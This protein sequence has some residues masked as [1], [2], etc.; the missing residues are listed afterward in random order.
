MDKETIKKEPSESQPEKVKEFTSFDDFSMNAKVEGLRPRREYVGGDP[1]EIIIV[2][3]KKYKK[4]V[5][6]HTEMDILGQ[7]VPKR[8]AT[9]QEYYSH[10][11]PGWDYRSDYMEKM[12]VDSLDPRDLSD[13]ILYELEEIES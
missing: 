6:Y 3:G 2:E 1:D 5:K 9:E 12:G 4:V 13:L 7:S 11:C 10:A 8:P